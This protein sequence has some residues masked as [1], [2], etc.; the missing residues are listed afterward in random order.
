MEYGAKSREKLAL[1]PLIFVVT[2][3]IFCRSVMVF[4]FSGSDALS[5]T[6]TPSRRNRCGASQVFADTL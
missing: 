2:G 5:T 3:A 1:S 4:V 6:E